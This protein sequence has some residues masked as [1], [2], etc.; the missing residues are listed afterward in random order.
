MATYQDTDAGELQATRP[1]GIAADT[2]T[3]VWAAVKDQPA[4]CWDPS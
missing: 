3:G 1:I 2:T 4:H